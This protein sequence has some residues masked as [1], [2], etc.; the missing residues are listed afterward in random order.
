MQKTLPSYKTVWV[1]VGNGGMGYGDYYWELYRDH[2]RDP[3][4]FPTKHQTENLNN[5]NPWQQKSGD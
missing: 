3:F 1:L 2:Y 4:P 5:L